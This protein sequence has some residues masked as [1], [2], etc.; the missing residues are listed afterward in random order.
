MTTAA[1]PN[2][3]SSISKKFRLKVS[4]T[5]I[6]RSDSLRQYN[7]AAEWFISY[8]VL[9]RRSMIESRYS[10]SDATASIGLIADWRTLPDF[11]RL[12]APFGV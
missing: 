10:H 3:N 6:F 1:I 11:A 9:A 4:M 7:T 5:P 8:R 12:S 2:A